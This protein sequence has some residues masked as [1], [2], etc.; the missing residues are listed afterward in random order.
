[1]RLLEPLHSAQDDELGVTTAA[2][3]WLPAT[4]R[5]EGSGGCRYGAT[6]RLPATAGDDVV[7][8]GNRHSE[9]NAALVDP[10]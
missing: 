1:M 3:R 10:A 4:A 9:R 2:T 6:R 7:S 5:D 8:L